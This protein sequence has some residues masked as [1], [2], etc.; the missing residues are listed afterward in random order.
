MPT[1]P[2]YTTSKHGIVGLTRA[3]GPVF[4]KEGI[5]VNCICP[6]FIP[7]GLAPPEIL[8]L[9]PKEHITP[10]STAIKAIDAFIEDDATT[11][12]VVELSQE[13]IYFREMVEYPN[14]SQR[15]MWTESLEI[16]EKGYAKIPKRHGD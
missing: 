12:K 4:L 8:A 15:W 7:T 10:L 5:T 13:N 11:G 16:W 1:N 3:A 9:W 6:A 2:Q 14:E